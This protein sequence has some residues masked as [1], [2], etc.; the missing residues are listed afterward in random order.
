[1]IDPDCRRNLTSAI[2]SFGGTPTHAY[3][4]QILL[5]CWTNLWR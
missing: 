2:T 4:S 5:A 1:M 3:G